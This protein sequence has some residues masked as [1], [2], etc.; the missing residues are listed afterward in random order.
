MAFGTTSSFGKQ[1][2]VKHIPKVVH[3]VKPLSQRPRR[4]KVAP[5]WDA[6]Q[7][8]ASVLHLTPSQ[9]RFA[10]TFFCGDNCLLSGAAGTGKSFLVKALVDFLNEHRVNVAVTASTG[11]AAFGIGGQ[12]IHSFAG[13][14]LADEPVDQII[15]EVMKRGK[16]KERIRA[17]HVLFLDEVSMIKGDLLD[18]VNAV[19]RA[20]RR[21]N[22]PWGGVQFCFVGDFLQLNPVFKGQEIQELAFESVSWRAA[23]IQTVVLQEQMRQH[24]DPILLKVLNDVRVGKTDSLHLLDGRIDASFPKDGVEG[25]RLFCKNVDVDTHNKERLRMLP[26]LSKTYLSYDSGIPKYIDSLDRNCP[27]PKV[28][29]LKVGA[30]VVLL[31][32][33]NIDEGLC[34][35]SVGVVKSFSPNG[36]NVQFL[37][38]TA[39]IDH[40]EWHIKEQEAGMDGKMMSKIRATR[41]QIPLKLAWASTVHRAQGQTLDRAILDMAEAFGVSMIYTSLSRVRDMESL[42]IVGSIPKDAIKVDPRCLTFYEAAER[43]EQVGVEEDDSLRF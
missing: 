7:R 3:P 41:R 21:S 4:G 31:C 37:K 32:N 27:A 33:V 2:P 22:D 42:S 38:T 23:D 36:V 35:G 11:V 15:S 30:S 8:H 34:N 14:G 39:M 19:F 5:L 18:K 17:T 1:Q 20:V 25:T 16:V 12:T 29:E 26:T 9:S 28:L 6:W 40:N 24:S 10:E 13:L 43:G